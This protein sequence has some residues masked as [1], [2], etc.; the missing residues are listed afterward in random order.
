MGILCP[1]QTFLTKIKFIKMKKYLILWAL[2][3]LTANLAVAQCPDSPYS[4][5]PDHWQNKV[6]ICKYIAPNNGGIKYA[7]SETAVVGKTVVFESTGLPI[8]LQGLI[9][10]NASSAVVSGETV[11]VTYSAVGKQTIRIPTAD[12]ADYILNIEIKE[13]VKTYKSPDAIWNIETPVAYNPVDAGAKAS[14]FSNNLITNGVMLSTKGVGRAYIRFGK[15][16]DNKIIRPIIYVDGIDFSTSSDIVH[17]ALLGGTETSESN[18][19]RYGSTGWDVF[20][21]GTEPSES[22]PDETEAFRKYPEHFDKMYEE[23]YDIIFLDF[24]EGATYMQKNAEVL[25]ELLN[26]INGTSTVSGQY[27][28]RKKVAA[29][30]GTLYENIVVGASMGGQVSKYALAKMEYNER[31]NNGPSHCTKLYV[32]FDSQ[33]KGA[34]VP[35][36]IQG[37]AWYAS[38]SCSNTS[39]WSKLNQPASRQLLVEHLSNLVGTNEITVKYS[40]ISDA[41]TLNPND[42]PNISLPADNGILR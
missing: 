28:N 13:P 31:T 29:S 34:V 12:P 5:T 37:A 41:G 40:I 16:H 15:N 26:Q 39:L 22:I 8:Y 20:A 23:G 25:I 3:C 17:D 36:G 7:I 4:F 2:C 24:K 1:K 35:L 38:S 30:D 9:F 32:S 19:V 11:T 18:I 42:F 10:S 14:H 6:R 33:H 21:M 27:P